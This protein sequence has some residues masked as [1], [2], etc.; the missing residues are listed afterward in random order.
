VDDFVSTDV[1]V[2]RL[3]SHGGVFSKL[4]VNNLPL[5]SSFLGK[6]AIGSGAVK[7]LPEGLF[8]D[9]ERSV[10]TI[11][12]ALSACIES[13]SSLSGKH[14]FWLS[15]W[16]TSFFFRIG[17]LAENMFS[18]GSEI[19]RLAEILNAMQEDF[20]NPALLKRIAKIETTLNDLLL[21]DRSGVRV[22]EYGRLKGKWVT[23]QL[24]PRIG[25]EDSLGAL[26]VPVNFGPKEKEVLNAEAFSWLLRKV[27]TNMAMNSFPMQHL[28]SVQDALV[29]AAALSDYSVAQNDIELEIGLPN[30]KSVLLTRFRGNVS[31]E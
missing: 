17:S 25:S 16:Y 9:L 7:S 23:E 30:S 18:L 29:R 22:S 14:Y 8:S 1:G 11:F 15:R 10:I 24:R 31:A 19:S 4:D 26:G 21:G 28:E 20:T 13:S 5:P 2:Q 27:D 12:D 3:L 6:W